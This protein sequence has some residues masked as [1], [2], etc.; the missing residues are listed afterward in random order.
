MQQSEKTGIT[1]P[2]IRLAAVW[3]TMLAAGQLPAPMTLAQSSD[4]QDR[5]RF[6]RFQQA[7]VLGSPRIGESSG[8]AASARYPGCYWTHNDNG[9]NPGLFLIQADG[10]LVATVMLDGA[11]FLDWEDV[12]TVHRQGRDLIVV[13]DVGDNL[14]RRETCRLF[15]LQ[16]PRLAG[17]D[18][19][20]R[21]QE[22]TID[23]IETIRFCYPDGPQDCE[24]MAIEASGKRIWLASKQRPGGA[25]A[26]NTGGRNGNLVD[27]AIH[28]L[29]WPD[30]RDARPLTAT[31]LETRFVKQM[32]TGM[33]FSR[34]DRMAVIRTYFGVHLFLRDP[35]ETWE[36]RLSRE[37]DLNSPVP[38]QRQGEA[39]AFDL[40]A[41]AVIL[42]SEGWSQPIWRIP[43]LRPTGQKPN[44][45]PAG[46]QDP[47]DP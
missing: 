35:E 28:F 40:D 41:T 47:V 12:A 14:A 18:E 17:G 1:R 9:H 24:A 39:I 2:G 30:P 26:Q 38:L 16:E 7:G 8:L 46:R 15:I 33:D 6:G 20:K 13:G 32:I 44:F 3:L 10:N 11:P 22:I 45:R 21:P 27:S 23:E 42:S 19:V 25:R 34:D 43:V 29:D 4:R 31:R 36:Q 5:V 37:P